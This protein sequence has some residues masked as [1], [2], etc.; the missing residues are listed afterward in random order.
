M[1]NTRRD[2]H[3]RSAS[4]RYFMSLQRRLGLTANLVRSHTVQ[5]SFQVNA[6]HHLSGV[7]N[8]DPRYERPHGHDY[9]VAVIIAGT[10]GQAGFLLEKVQTEVQLNQILN[11]LDHAYL[12]EIPAIGV[13][14]E[15]NLVKYIASIVECWLEENVPANRNATVAAVVSTRYDRS[16]PV[17]YYP[18]QRSHTSFFMRGHEQLFEVLRPYV[19]GGRE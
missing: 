16:G 1:V 14:T 11:H 3:R 10:P 2:L 12:N 18:P 7:D 13:P 6:Q 8:G 15:E 17:T 19:W 5:F 9:N 4:S